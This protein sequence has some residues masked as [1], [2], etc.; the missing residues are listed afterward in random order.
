ML[1]KNKGSDEQAS[2]GGGTHL[3]CE[4]TSPPPKRE[5]V[6]SSPALPRQNIR[7]SL[8]LGRGELYG[9]KLVPSCCQGRRKEKKGP[10]AA[11]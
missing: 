4:G 6:T 1:T 3:F 7:F 5:S 8:D 2:W 11:C 10:R 9:A